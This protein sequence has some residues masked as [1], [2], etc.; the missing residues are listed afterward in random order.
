MWQEICRRWSV[1]SKLIMDGGGEKS[2]KT[3]KYVMCRCQ[4]K[5]FG[6]RNIETRCIVLV[7][8]EVVC[9]EGEIECVG[10]C[11]SVTCNRMLSGIV[12]ASAMAIKHGVIII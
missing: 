10:K 5:S 8:A 6:S 4:D 7:E 1:L 11:T 9:G 2:Q 12:I 3:K